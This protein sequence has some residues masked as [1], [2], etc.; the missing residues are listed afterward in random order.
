MA[1]SEY[2]GDPLEQ[3]VLTFSAGASGAEEDAME[4]YTFEPIREYAIMTFK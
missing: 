4:R 3:I 1:V 2:T